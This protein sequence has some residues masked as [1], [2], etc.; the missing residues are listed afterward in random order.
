MGSGIERKEIPTNSVMNDSIGFIS[1]EKEFSCRE[2][3]S[4][5]LAFIHRKGS[6]QSVDKLKTSERKE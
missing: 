3:V 2:N 5:Q 6:L 4:T 1:S